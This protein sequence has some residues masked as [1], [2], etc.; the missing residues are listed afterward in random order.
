MRVILGGLSL[1][2]LGL[3]VDAARPAAASHAV[4][5]TTDRGRT[6]SQSDEGLPGQARINAFAA[7]G[8]SVLAGTDA[9]LFVSIDEGVRWQPASGAAMTSGRIL[10]L[11]SAGRNVYAGTDR[12][13]VLVSA[14]QG[15]TWTRSASFPARYVRSLLGVGATVYAGTDTQGV[16]SSEDG[17]VSWAGMSD[18]LPADGQIF[19]MTR[20]KGSLF[21]GL[22]AKGL[23]NWQEGLR[24]W[25]RVGPVVPLVLAPAGGT[26]IVGHNPGGLLWSTDLGRTWTQ[27]A[28]AGAGGAGELTKDAPVWEAGAGDGIVYAGAAEGIYFS[29]DQG[30]SWTRA[31]SG[32]PAVS[33]GIAFLDG[34]GFALAGVVVRGA[35]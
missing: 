17:G 28:A 9:G 32:L 13:G 27:G 24:R 29:E 16:F 14:D 19:T 10:S 33:S 1:V 5:R 8:R 7:M 31:R 30:R 2:G 26:L 4:F 23:W 34:G 18:G 21:A 22:Y 11:A 6:W 12:S 15:R 3:L 25:V 20:V 35:E